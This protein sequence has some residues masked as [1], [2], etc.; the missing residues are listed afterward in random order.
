MNAI[1]HQ[2]G[3]RGGHPQADCTPVAI[4]PKHQQADD[5]R[6][7]HGQ[8]HDPIMNEPGDPGFGLC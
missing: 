4:G 6:R 3:E 8:E 5:Q 2:I 1:V 7:E